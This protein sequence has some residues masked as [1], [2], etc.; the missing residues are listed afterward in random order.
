M[1][2]QFHLNEEG[3]FQIRQKYPYYGKSHQINEVYPGQR[4]L[5]LQ[6]FHNDIISTDKEWGFPYKGSRII[7]IRQ[8]T[9]E[10][11]PSFCSSFQNNRCVICANWFYEKDKNKNKVS[12][13]KEN[14]LLFLAGFFQKNQFVILTTSPNE[15]MKPIHPRMPILIKESELSDWFS[16]YYLPYLQREQEE[17]L[18]H[19]EMEQVA[20]F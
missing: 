19:R 16:D 20:L 15:T 2:G 1:C 11:K 3:S 17:L 8:E 13:Y 7:N 9:V 18:I 5:I 12:F 10:T 6:S 4:A 14:E